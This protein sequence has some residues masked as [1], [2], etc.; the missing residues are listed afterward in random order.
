[1]GYHT[2]FTGQI[3]VDPPLSEEEHEYLTKFAGTRRMNRT[4]G[5]Y[6]VDGTGMYGQGQDSDSVEGTCTIWGGCQDANNSH[7]QRS[8][9]GQRAIQ[10]CCDGKH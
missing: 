9:S 3:T 6:F 7:S 10:T 2:E 5:P 1:M 8:T 4:K